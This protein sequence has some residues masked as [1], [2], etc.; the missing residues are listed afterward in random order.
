MSPWSLTYVTEYELVL[1]KHVNFTKWKKTSA[2]DFK[3]GLHKQ[4]KPLRPIIGFDRT[5]GW[6]YSTKF[7]TGRIWDVP[8]GVIFC[9]SCILMLL[10]I[11]CIYF[12]NTFFIMLCQSCRVPITTGII[13]GFHPPHSF[14]DFDL[15][16][17]IFWQFFSGMVISKSRQVLSCLFLI[18]MSGLLA[19]ISRS[20][21]QSLY[22]HLPQDC[23][24]VF[25][26]YCL[27]LY[28]SL[29]RCFGVDTG[30]SNDDL[31]LNTLKTLLRLPRVLKAF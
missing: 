9:G 31:P 11:C 2:I 26:C 8:S 4:R 3:P 12:S 16:V 19:F 27:C 22:W 20:V 28:S 24:T 14:A 6:G 7:Y 23:D 5:R 17:F 21:C 30:T 18:T 13:G 1:L 25:F 15:K 29:C 10:G